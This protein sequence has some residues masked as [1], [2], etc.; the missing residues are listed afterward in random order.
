MTK[1]ISQKSKELCSILEKKGFPYE[2][3]VLVSQELNTDFTAKQMIG[4][5]YQT[6]R[7]SMESIV[8]EMLAILSQR[9]RIVEK[10]IL[11]KNQEAL[12]NR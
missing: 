11:E 5:L 12:N 9:D 10:K 1:K 7:N 2:F 8:D 3:C 6:N 4:Y